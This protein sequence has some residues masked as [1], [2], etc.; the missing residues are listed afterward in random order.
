[1]RTN[2]MSFKRLKIEDYSKRFL[3]LLNKLESSTTFSEQNHWFED[4]NKH[5]FLF[6]TT[7]N[8][9]RLQ[10]FQNLEDVFFQ[11]EYTFFN[12]IEP[13]YLNLVA[14]YYQVILSSK[15]RPQLEEQWG[16]Q[17]FRLADVKVKTFSEEVVKDLQY[18]NKLVSEYQ[19][20]LGKV[21]FT[22]Q[23]KELNFSTLS[24]Y[25]GSKDRKIRKQAF[26]AKSFYF[27]QH[28][29]EFDRL[30]DQLVKTRTAIARKLGYSSFIQLGYD[31]M[32]RT[33]FTSVELSNYRKQVREYGVPFVSSL[34]REQCKRIGVDRL[35]YYDE[36]LK[37]PKGQPEPIGEIENILEGF[38]RMF[39][40]MSPETEA[41]FNELVDGKMFDLESRSGKMGGAFATYIGE[42]NNPF[43]FANFNKTSNDIRVF[44][45]EAGH[46]F[47][48]YMSR[49][50]NI[51]E[52][53]IPYDSAE[54]FSFT[55]E[56]FAWPWMEMFFTKDTAQYKFAHLTNAFH[57]MPLACVV[58]EFE[59]FIY[60][61]PDAS[62]DDRRK[63]WR[64]LEQTYLP[65]R[66]YNGDQFLERGGGFYEIGHMFTTPFYFMDYEL[67]HFCSV[68]F[69][70]LSSKN[71]K[72]AWDSF[73]K[74]CKIGGSKSY[75]ELIT[76]ANLTSP[77]EENSL[78]PLLQSVEKWIEQG[79]VLD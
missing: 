9:V 47:Q 19:Q 67:A 52:Y 76:D 72:L 78:Q 53:I 79:D 3:N 17:L 32:S 33:S 37:F 75:L 15:F 28:R 44:T 54:L 2:Q 65:E 48:F 29:F 46:A 55:M 23:G 11:K 39:V 10:Y 68:Q 31:R 20:L 64:E 38:K 40:Q 73:I 25:L 14:Q 26:E 58:D 16:K 56:R 71:P 30:L 6:E 41:F 13:N 27:E 49:H 57:Y 18:E 34:K 60:E 63:K 59:H 1:M 45:H 42:N 36:E 50:W 21:S 8:F 51:P 74:M 69:W 4:L 43:I 24:P 5:R 70:D 77:F 61:E 35:K 62:P 12:Q 66:D 22:F 7:Q